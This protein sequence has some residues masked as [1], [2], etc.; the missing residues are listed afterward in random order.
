MTDGH[1]FIDYY[2]ILQVSPDC[3]GK[4]LETAYRQLAKTYHPDHTE[5]ADVTKFN[6]VIEAYRI[7][8]NPE[9][10]AKYDVQYTNNT[11]FE[12]SPNGELNGDERAALS[13]ADAHAKILMFLYRR[14]REH[15]Q[16]AG[17]GRYFVQEMLDCSDENFDFHIWYLKAKGFIE[18]TEQGTLAI[19]IEGVDHVISMSRTTMAEKKLIAQSSNLQD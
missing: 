2:E 6:E 17:V 8:R 19:T 3:D 18:T 4:V 7:L 1:T 11:G 15:A 5:T 9:Q 12:F 16:D 13:D 14:R 10:R